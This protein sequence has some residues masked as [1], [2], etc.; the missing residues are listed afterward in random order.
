[1]ESAIALQ[2]TSALEELRAQDGE[3]N[4]ASKLD[5]PVFAEGQP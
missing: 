5:W 4:G 2:T 3:S 1:M